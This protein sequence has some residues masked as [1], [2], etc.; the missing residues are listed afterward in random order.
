MGG[1][2]WLSLAKAIRTVVG[3]P[4]YT[5]KQRL[6]KGRFLDFWIEQVA[7]NMNTEKTY[8]EFLDTYVSIAYRLGY[9]NGAYCYHSIKDNRAGI[10]EGIGSADRHRNSQDD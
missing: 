2:E 9:I 5:K 1:D 10:G 4:K 8:I 3:I 7:G 6:I